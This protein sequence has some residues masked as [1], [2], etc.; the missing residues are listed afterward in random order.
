MGGITSWVRLR[1]YPNTIVGFLQGGTLQDR[2][3]VQRS[4]RFHEEFLG[5]MGPFERYF[6]S[7]PSF[8]LS[9]PFDSNTP[10]Q[11][12]DPENLLTMLHTWASGDVSNQSPYNGDFAAAMRAIKAQMLVLPG[13][14][15]LYF[16]YVFSL[17][18]L[19]LLFFNLLSIPSPL[20]SSNKPH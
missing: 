1:G 14:T 19:L 13:K 4:R 5:E 9:H 3:G 12:T 7:C 11:K 15:D 8:L 18:F 10:P 20:L 17:P 6:L 16:P 2:S